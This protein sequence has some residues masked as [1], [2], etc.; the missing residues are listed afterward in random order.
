MS[1]DG[2]GKPSR[3]RK[4]PVSLPRIGRADI[5]LQHILSGHSHGGY[6]VS[7]AKTVFPSEWSERQIESAILAAYRSGK[8]VITQGNRV[9]VKGDSHG[10]TI[11][12]WVNME[13]KTIE[14]AYPVSQSHGAAE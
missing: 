9:K 1:E 10:M 12:M 2:L 11:E 3:K 7:S 5:D 8:R 13:T 14:T 4:K 6:R